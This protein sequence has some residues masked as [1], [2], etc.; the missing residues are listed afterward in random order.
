MVIVNER[1]PFSS[2]WNLVYLL[3]SQSLVE[4]EVELGGDRLVVSGMSDF[5][6]FG[7]LYLRKGLSNL[8]PN[9]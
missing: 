1:V 9:N 2:F 8:L 7:S 5:H 4:V 3:L 6:Q